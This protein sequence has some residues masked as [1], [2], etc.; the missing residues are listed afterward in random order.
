MK[1]N[2]KLTITTH[3][4]MILIGDVITS[5]KSV[6]L[7]TY[8]LKYL[9]VPSIFGIII[10]YGTAYYVM[11]QLTGAV[12]DLELSTLLWS[13]CFG[14]IVGSISGLNNRAFSESIE[15]V[16]LAT[17]ELELKYRIE[18]ERLEEQNRKLLTELQ[19]DLVTGLPNRRQFENLL[20]EEWTRLRR[21]RKPISILICEIQ[22]DSKFPV[23]E[24]YAEIR[25]ISELLRNEMKRSSDAVF[26]YSKKTLICLLP[27][28]DSSGARIVNNRIQ[29]ALDAQRT[30]RLINTETQIY[31]GY[32]TSYASSNVSP[33]ELLEIGEAQLMKQ[34][35]STSYISA[36]A[37]VHKLQEE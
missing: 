27:E 25:T 29:G 31:F 33:A 13:V 10:A 24:S 17:A 18:L 22:L 32:G 11:Y 4:T 28:T 20:S 23:L 35:I 6:K 34:K 9:I 7:C 12:A 16:Q 1:R 15:I 2:K 14:M 3:E 8:L 5:M 26:R 37:S 30:L 19:R 21:T 36:E